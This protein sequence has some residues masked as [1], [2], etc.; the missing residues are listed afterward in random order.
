MEEL[1]I[2]AENL[3]AVTAA[4]KELRAEADRVETGRE[5]RVTKSGGGG[6]QIGAE[7]LGDNRDAE[8]FGTRLYQSI[9]SA[10]RR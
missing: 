6:T 5:A 8:A 10:K 2:L 7:S 3:R 9:E 4:S 1:R